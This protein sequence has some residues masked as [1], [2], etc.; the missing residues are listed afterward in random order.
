[1]RLKLKFTKLQKNY[2]NKIAPR[3]ALV[4]IISLTVLVTV[5]HGN[6]L[7]PVQNTEESLLQQDFREDNLSH[8][9]REIISEIKST[10][11]IKKFEE[12][13]RSPEES[14]GVNEPTQITETLIESIKEIQYHMADF[15]LQDD[16]APLS[17]N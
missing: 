15:N 14:S 17:S 10:D 6:R 13:N 1:M 3:I 4:V 16:F 9:E 12:I 2:N 8:D 7:N 5:I 11:L